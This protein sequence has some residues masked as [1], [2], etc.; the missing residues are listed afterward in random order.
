MSE[1]EAR[2]ED[3]DL[4]ARAEEAEQ[5]EYDSA[6]HR[7][8]WVSAKAAGAA[9]R[10]AS[11]GGPAVRSSIWGADRTASFVGRFLQRIPKWVPV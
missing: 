6:T 3:A 10:R 8:T 5:E 2:V 1:P 4:E 7:R 9:R 11:R